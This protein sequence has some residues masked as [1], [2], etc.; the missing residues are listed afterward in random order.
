MKTH[1][2]GQIRL[3]VWRYGSRESPS[4]N[5]VV[6]TVSGGSLHVTMAC[7]WIVKISVSVFGLTVFE[8]NFLKKTFLNCIY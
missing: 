5:I 3:S 8:P 7:K 2:T 4:V 1:K 6:D